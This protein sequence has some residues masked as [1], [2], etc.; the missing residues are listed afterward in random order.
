LGRKKGAC[1]ECIPGPKAAS[2]G[3]PV[4]R[5]SARFANASIELVLDVASGRETTWADRWGLHNALAVFNPAP[6]T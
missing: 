4:E 3:L 6:V 1:V 5:A 2:R